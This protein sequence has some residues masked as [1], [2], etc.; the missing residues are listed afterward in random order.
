MEGR[1]R[2]YRVRNAAIQVMHWLNVGLPIRLRMAP[3]RLH[4]RIGIL[5]A[6]MMMEG[7]NLL[8]CMVSTHG[9]LI[10][11]RQSTR[12]SFE[13]MLLKLVATSGTF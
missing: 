7:Q 12:E 5:M 3:L 8:I 6:V 4:L 10:V 1:W 13:V 2:D 9:R 11:F